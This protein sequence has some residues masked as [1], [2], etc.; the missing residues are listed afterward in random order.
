M[1]NANYACKGNWKLLSLKN[2]V[3]LSQG[4]LCSGG[5]IILSSRTLLKLSN[6]KYLIVAIDHTIT[7]IN[8][9]EFVFHCECPKI[10]DWFGLWPLNSLIDLFFYSHLLLTDYHDWT[11][12]LKCFVKV[13]F[14]N[15]KLVHWI[16]PEKISK[17]FHSISVTI[18]FLGSE[19]KQ[20]HKQKKHSITPL[21]YPLTNTSLNTHRTYQLSNQQK[22]ALATGD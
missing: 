10:F 1:L 5:H 8:T 17:L 7:R 11:I 9:L 22:S 18:H 21:L 14:I 4:K 16:T 15:V 20:K 12:T 13:C 19:I 2:P 6:L 3:C